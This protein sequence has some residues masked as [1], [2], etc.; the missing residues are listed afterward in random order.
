MNSG[1]IS[2]VIPVYNAGEYLEKC[3]YSVIKQSYPDLEIILINDGST[4]NSLE[5]ME[6]FKNQDERIILINK[7]NG[8]VSSARNRGI[9]TATGK[10]II[11]IDADDYIEPTMF[12]V[13][14]GYLFKNS[15]DISMCGYRNVDING[16][17]LYESRGMTE[18]YFDANTFRTNLFNNDYYRGDIICNK[19]FKLEIIKENN[20]RFREDIH[21]KENILFLLDFSNYAFRYSY[22]ERALYNFLYNTSG[23]THG[24]F[25][26]KKVSVLSAYIRLL[27]Y[28]LENSILNRIKY[29]YLFAGYAFTYMMKKIGLDNTD[30]KKNLKEFKAKYYKDIKKD[31]NI[32]FK[33]KLSL[34]FM[35][36]FNSIYCKFRKDIS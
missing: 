4:D 18:K 26:L 30:L 5:I 3:L 29:R 31:K 13:M 8:G 27:T 23:A 10:Y 28:N 19:L 15:V 36:H 11:F 21:V 24:K 22:D 12:E 33:K 6:K 25:S 17:I 16:N 35:I 14:S 1:K 9:E 7:E 32:S 20:I 34:W 2:V